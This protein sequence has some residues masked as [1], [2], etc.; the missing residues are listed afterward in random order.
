MFTLRTLS[1]GALHNVHGTYCFSFWVSDSSAANFLEAT[2]PT[3]VSECQRVSVA[4]KEFLALYRDMLSCGVVH[5][6][7]QVGFISKTLF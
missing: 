2:R 7:G 4:P 5:Y 1:R 6:A 3:R